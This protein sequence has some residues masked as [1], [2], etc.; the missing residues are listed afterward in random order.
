M[1]ARELA[2]YRVNSISIERVLELEQDETAVRLVDRAAS[3]VSPTYVVDSDLHLDDETAITALVADYLAQAQR[4]GMVPMTKGRLS[5]LLG[6]AD[7][8]T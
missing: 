1:T 6:A 5:A 2:R 8:D 3:G 4:M 7:H